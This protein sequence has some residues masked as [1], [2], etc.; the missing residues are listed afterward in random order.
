[1]FCA[2]SPIGQT[3]CFFNV[4]VPALYAFISVMLFLYFAF[5]LLLLKNAIRMRSLIGF[6]Y[7]F[8]STCVFYM[9]SIICKRV[10]CFISIC[11]FPFGLDCVRVYLHWYAYCKYILLTKHSRFKMRNCTRSINKNQWGR[12]QQQCGNVYARHAPCT[13]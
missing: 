4:R 5:F 11:I 13:K 1:M 7:L 10:F 6:R 12:Q 8:I 3:C 2:F 9:H